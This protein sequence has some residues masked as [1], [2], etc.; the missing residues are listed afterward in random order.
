[1]AENLA[2]KK[3]LLGRCGW[4]RQCLTVVTRP[5]RIMRPRYSSGNGGRGASTACSSAFHNHPNRYSEGEHRNG[6]SGKNR[7]SRVTESVHFYPYL[8]EI[9]LI[10]YISGVKHFATIWAPKFKL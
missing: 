9:F 3:D 6:K 4:V 5:F 10:V 2:L 1:L 7:I 8:N